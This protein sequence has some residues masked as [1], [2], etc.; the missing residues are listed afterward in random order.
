MFKQN[1]SI[2]SNTFENFALLSR[3]KSIDLIVKFKL[4]FEK[5]KF[6]SC[7]LNEKINEIFKFEIRSK[8]CETKKKL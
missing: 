8:G 4:L 2:L 5:L 6:E 7:T 1:D 3:S